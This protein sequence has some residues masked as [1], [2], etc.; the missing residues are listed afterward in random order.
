MAE[1]QQ[2]IREMDAEHDRTQRQFRQLKGE[3]DIKSSVNAALR[4]Q[5]AELVRQLEQRSVQYQSTR[6]VLE[7]QLRQ[8][9]ELNTSRTSQSG[10]DA[11]EDT[12]QLLRSCLVGLRQELSELQ[13]SL[14]AQ[15]SAVEHIIRISS[16][17]A[18]PMLWSDRS[19]TPNNHAH[20]KAVKAK[21][22][23]LNANRA[24]LQSQSLLPRGRTSSP[25]LVTTAR[26]GSEE[27]D[28]RAAIRSASTAHNTSIESEAPRSVPRADAIRSTP[29][30]PP[31]LASAVV[32]AQEQLDRS[33]KQLQSLQARYLKTS[34][35][36]VF[37]PIRPK[38]DT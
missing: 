8:A 31:V 4:D 14:Q 25:A 22:K 26:L 28:A 35:A 38:S 5:T 16:N 18:S 27:F 33:R 21:L 11:K 34:A 15:G 32:T 23:Q 30:R 19:G 2:V 7:R 9:S 10:A 17:P 37:S 29:I 6:D 24:R 3:L 36:S 20:L 1:L 13:T 12:V